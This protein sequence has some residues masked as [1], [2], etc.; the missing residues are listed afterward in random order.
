MTAL[1]RHKG[2]SFERLVARHL[3]DLTGLK[4]R[5]Q[6][7][8]YQDR[9]HG[10]LVTDDGKFAFLIECKISSTN[11]F[12]EAWREQATTA[13]TRTAQ[14]PAIVFRLAAGPIRVTLS[15]EAISAAYGALAEKPQ[16]YS[17]WTEIDLDGL[18]YLAREISAREVSHG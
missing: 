15:M 6:L 8:Q 1:S 11:S 2:A 10:D 3:L 9:E 14:W 17:H 7:R 12:R 18:A 4:F 16:V 13:A 5:R